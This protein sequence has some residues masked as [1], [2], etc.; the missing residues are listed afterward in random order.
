MSGPPYKAIIEVSERQV[1]FEGKK[2]KLIAI[3]RNYK[4][5][6]VEKDKFKEIIAREREGLQKGIEEFMKKGID[7][8]NFIAHA[9]LESNITLASIRNGKIYVKYS[10]EED[11]QKQLNKILGELVKQPSP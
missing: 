3:Y 10:Q 2:T 5:R 4:D 7:K 8:R 9:S 11:M 6:N 1:E